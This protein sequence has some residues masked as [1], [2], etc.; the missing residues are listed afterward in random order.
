MG[1]ALGKKQKVSS[2][3][4]DSKDQEGI[5]GG[6]FSFEEKPILKTLDGD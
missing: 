2:L 5:E 4:A 3:D 1:S 6:K